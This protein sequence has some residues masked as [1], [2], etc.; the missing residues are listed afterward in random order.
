MS[1]PIPIYYRIPLTI[2]EPPL[3]LAGALM[4]HF[5]PDAFLT[6]MTPAAA[7]PEALRSVRILTDQ[8]GIFELIFA[9]N[10]A[11]VLRCTRDPRVWRVMCA[12][13]LLSD[14]LHTGASVRELGWAVTL[15]P[16]S[17][18]SEEW[19]NFGVLGVMGL[20]RLGVVLGIGLG[21]GEGE[22]RK[23]G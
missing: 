22:K 5:T 10:C 1:H 16:A 17:W 3:A 2:I 12:G 6:S 14:V 4:L 19:I 11:I 13:M 23:M 8:L 21:S 7:S 9:F 18:R 20:V 15:S